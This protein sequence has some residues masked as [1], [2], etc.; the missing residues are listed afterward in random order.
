MAPASE[1]S[2]YCCPESILGF[3]W[4]GVA[5]TSMGVL[6]ACVDTVD[7]SKIDP[8]RVKSETPL[9]FVSRQNMIREI[10]VR[11][12]F[13]YRKAFHDISPPCFEAKILFV[14]LHCVLSQA[15][16]NSDDCYRGSWSLAPPNQVGLES[17]FVLVRGRLFQSLFS[18]LG[19]AA[20]QGWGYLRVASAGSHA[21]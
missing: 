9:S 19:V 1:T 12:F 2:W 6:R 17:S 14:L 21:R 11:L 4:A 5:C 10:F 7:C 8:R 18:L 3:R 13:G 20:R 16:G 15:F